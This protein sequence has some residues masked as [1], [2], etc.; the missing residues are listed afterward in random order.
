MA[1]MTL[2][3]RR[4]LAVAVAVSGTSLSLVGCALYTPRKNLIEDNFREAATIDNKKVWLSHQGAVESDIIANIRCQVRTGLYDAF[5]NANA[6]WLYNTGTSIALNLTWDETANVA[7][8]ST[9]AEPISAGTL[10]TWAANAGGSAHSTREED[11]GFNWDNSILLEEARINA[12]VDRRPPTCEHEERG[13][14]MS[15]DLG[16]GEFIF[17]KA[18]IA[19]RAEIR[20]NSSIDY[21]QFSTFQEKVTFVI[22]VGVGATPSWKLTRLAVNPSGSFIGA[23]RKKTSLLILTIGPLARKQ[24]PNGQAI[25]AEQARMQH[26][27]AVYGAQTR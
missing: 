18:T 9:F 13:V 21:P 25:L 6:P 7:A 24:G 15:N 16:I 5:I 26:D 4:A 3:V 14:G 1:R 19:A 10:F 22:D 2:W 12:Q 23:D 11:I 17:D 20:P 27:A 8:S